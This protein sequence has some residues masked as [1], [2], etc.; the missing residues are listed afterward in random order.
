MKMIFFTTLC[1]IIY[2]LLT[3]HS[4]SAAVMESNPIWQEKLKEYGNKA[5]VRQVIFVQYLGGSSAIVKL[6]EKNKDTAW[7]LVLECDG[8]VGKYGIGKT[9]E[10]DKKT[11]KGDFGI[12]TA[13]GIKKNPGTRADYL[14][15]DEHIFCADG[16]YYN[17]LIDDRNI[18]PEVLKK[19]EL[20]PMN[21][22]APQF[23]Y[24]LFVDYNK[25]CIPG[26]GSYIFIHCIGEYD[27]T[28]GC[29][30]VSEEN[31][32]KI[33]QHVDNNVRICIY[34]A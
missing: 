17:K 22:G 25:E 14:L 3:M 7:K 18:P 20:D 24:G 26:R 21:N 16:I 1:F 2:N 10:G 31:M 15:F 28:Q 32:K 13:G 8:F 27:Y 19:L 23:N 9:M 11:P 12:I 4:V 29:V 6:Y 34:S 5:Q 33:I 30:A